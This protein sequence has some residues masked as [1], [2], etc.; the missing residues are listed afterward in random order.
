[1]IDSKLEKKLVIEITGKDVEDILAGLRAGRRNLSGLDKG[2][3]DSM[4]ALITTI[5]LALDRP[6]S[7]REE[8]N[9]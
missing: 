3:R 1:M 4:D 8:D 9:V 7:S 5:E 2:I 6:I